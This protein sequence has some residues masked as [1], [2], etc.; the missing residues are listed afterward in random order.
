MPETGP[1]RAAR[2]GS[3][4]CLGARGRA[5]LTGAV[6][7]REPWIAEEA[8]PKGGL[9]AGWATLVRSPG[10]RLAGRRNFV[11][12]S[13]PA[14]AG[15]VL[16]KLSD[17][18]ASSAPEKP[19]TAHETAPIGMSRPRGRIPGAVAAEPASAGQRGFSREGN[20]CRLE[21]PSWDVRTSKYE[22]QVPVPVLSPPCPSR[23]RGGGGVCGARHPWRHDT[24][25]RI[26]HAPAP[27]LPRLVACRDDGRWA[28]ADPPHWRI[29]VRGHCGARHVG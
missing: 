22:Y 25:P 16:I 9:S 28:L 4:A 23:A 17:P 5:T 29:A 7:G 6:W 11:I 24:R 18:P 14:V 27:F 3:L 15:P 1:P 26:L 21:M 2:R 10:R 12:R 20:M 13:S 19:P 8:V